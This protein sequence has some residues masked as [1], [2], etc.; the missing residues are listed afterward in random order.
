[1][2]V[3]RARDYEDM[4][5]KASQLVVDKINESNVNVLGLATGG[6]PV[7]LY[8]RLIKKINKG[9]ASFSNIHTV[10]LDEYIGLSADDPNSYHRYMDDVLFKHINIPK[11]QTHLPN[12][13]A[14]DVQLEC[15][16]YEALIH[17]LGGV[18]LQ[19]LGIGNNGHI[20]F[21]EPGS[22]FS[23]RT[24]VVE[25][26]PSTIEANARYFSD[27]EMV[28]RQAITMGIQTI[29]ESKGIL[30][31]AS[32]L[33]KAEAIQELIEGEVSESCPATVLQKHS[34][35]TI[36]ADEQALSLVTSL[37]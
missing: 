8:K 14:E 37:K 2:N 33:D 1:M 28:P 15:L 12:G 9:K 27:E 34:D 10:N 19:L 26:A 29:I 36:I 25:L 24:Q 5:E 23:G 31:L 4:S 7:G 3:I 20:G 21:N 22:S 35:L 32:G 18:D 17:E 16:R 11:S 13:D 30:L 6:T